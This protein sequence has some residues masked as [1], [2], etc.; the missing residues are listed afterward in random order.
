MTTARWRDRTTRTWTGSSKCLCY[1]CRN[2]FGSLSAFERHQKRGKCLDPAAVGLEL[3]DDV[4]RWPSRD[5]PIAAGESL[6]TAS[7]GSSDL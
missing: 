7:G 6:K 3:K 2:L 1:A 5:A 4:W